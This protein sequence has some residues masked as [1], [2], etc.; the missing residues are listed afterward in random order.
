MS[1]TGRKSRRGLAY[2]LALVIGAVAGGGSALA[3][4]GL[5]PGF[6]A[7][8]DGTV[9]LD[10]WK[11]DFSTGSEAADAY[12][13]ARIARHGLLALAR[14]EAVYFTRNTDDQGERLREGCRYRLS[15]GKMP[16]QWWSVTLYDAESRL[17]MNT[18]G[19]LS[20][21]ASRAGEEAWSATI[22]PQ[23]PDEGLWL[24]SQGGGQFDLTL[25]LYVTEARLIK[26]P[27]AT[28]TPPRVERQDCAGG[29][30]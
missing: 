25:R 17:P 26:D 10:G 20:L 16:A 30:A 12:T 13:R 22:A 1:E 6:G 4:S 3:L 24:S 19:A 9:N 28:L 2:G 5:F 21:D 8:S 27:V 18:D 14:T 29:A 7:M 11:A 23:A 15:G